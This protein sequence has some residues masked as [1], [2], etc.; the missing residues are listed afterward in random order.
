MKV[1][2][3]KRF[4]ADD[5][6]QDLVEYA[7]LTALIGIAAIATWQVIADRV[8]IAY[9]GSNTDVQALAEPADPQ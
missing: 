4:V 2:T 8:G 9:A 6:G 3:L 1:L 5:G 7:L